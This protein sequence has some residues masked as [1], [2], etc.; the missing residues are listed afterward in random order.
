MS[1]PTSESHHPDPAK[2]EDSRTLNASNVSDSLSALMSASTKAEEIGAGGDSVLCR[3]IDSVSVTS[4]SP[5]ERRAGIKPS[6]LKP[7]SKIS[8]LCAGA[9]KPGLPVSPPKS[10]FFIYSLNFVACV[11]L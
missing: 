2:S 4:D 9:Q 1:E 7:P 6:G 8:R 10:E 5:S 11:F 3:D